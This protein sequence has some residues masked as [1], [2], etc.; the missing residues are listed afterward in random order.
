MCLKQCRAS[1]LQQEHLE[2][3]SEEQKA[4]LSSMQLLT[5]KMA[6]ILLE[7]R[8]T[9]VLTLPLPHNPLHM[10]FLDLQH[11]EKDPLSKKSLNNLVSK[12]LVFQHLGPLCF[13]QRTVKLTGQSPSCSRSII[14]TC[15]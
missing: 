7:N 10:S 2:D 1:D 5:Y 6:L 15:S 14:Y 4:L 3:Q 13:S 11:H 8:K 9:Q 12:E